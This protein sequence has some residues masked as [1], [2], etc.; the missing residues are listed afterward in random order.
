MVRKDDMARRTGE[1]KECQRCSKAEE[2]RY[3][4]YTDAMDI[5]V[6]ASCAEEAR[7]IGMPVEN[8]L[9]CK[10]TTNST[11]RSETGETS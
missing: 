4:V 11:T 7:K 9:A 3:R 8:L 1:A 10:R 5:Q 2:P 6:C